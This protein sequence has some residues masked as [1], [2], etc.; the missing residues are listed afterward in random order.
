MTIDESILHVIIVQSLE[1]EQI[2][3]VLK[4]QDVKW[5]KWQDALKEFY[6]NET[7]YDDGFY[8]LTIVTSQFQNWNYIFCR[9]FEDLKYALNC[10]NELSKTGKFLY[11]FSVDVHSG[12]YGF[13]KIEDGKISRLF[14]RNC[15]SE[16][17]EFGEPLKEETELDK[18]NDE[19]DYFHV[20]QVAEKLLRLD[21]IKESCS[22]N[23]EVLVGKRYYH[24]I[25]KYKNLYLEPAK[26][27]TSMPDVG[28]RDD[29]PF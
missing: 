13:A 3:M 21:L 28:G 11:Y 18:E 29:L 5:C 1:V 23:E 25:E 16:T 26:P 2:S 9:K 22:N 10:C 17:G 27:N 24:E 14:L 19:H 4:M 20:V 6:K 8:E 7:F 15:N 12:D